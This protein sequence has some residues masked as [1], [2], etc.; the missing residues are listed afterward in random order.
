M[1][2]CYFFYKNTCKIRCAAWPESLLG[3]GL[4]STG[5]QSLTCLVLAINMSP[6][7]KGSKIERLG[8][9]DC[10]D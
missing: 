5:D 7:W 2:P 10:V 4:H 8:A 9:L 3:I 1:H 6:V